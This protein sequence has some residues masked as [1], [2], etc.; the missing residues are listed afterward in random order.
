MPRRLASLRTRHLDQGATAVEYAL[1][2]M[3]IALVIIGAVTALG[4]AL[5]PHFANATAGL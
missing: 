4:T 5:I 1:M 2:A 3:L